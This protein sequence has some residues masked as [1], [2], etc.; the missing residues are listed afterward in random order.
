MDS[1]L[2][3]LTCSLSYFLGQLHV[4]FLLL[5]PMLIVHDER[6]SIWLVL[7]FLLLQKQNHD[8][9]FFIDVQSR[10]KYPNYLLKRLEREE[11]TLPIEK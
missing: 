8:N 3:Q 4:Q 7:Y 2:Q 5:K 10:G 6:L 11:I 1:N 9:L